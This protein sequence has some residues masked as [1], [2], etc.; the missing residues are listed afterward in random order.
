[1][2]IATFCNENDGKTYD[3]L[4]V[5]AAGTESTCVSSADLQSVTVPVNDAT[6]NHI[7]VVC[8][9]GLI[10]RKVRLQ[11]T[12]TSDS[13]SITLHAIAIM[14]SDCAACSDISFVLPTQMYT[15][16]VPVPWL[17]T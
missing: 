12:S 8:D 4:I 10:G 1:M 11:R 15:N 16:G 3:I 5:S 14:I 13:G 6:S 2:G 7:D 17:R 9:S